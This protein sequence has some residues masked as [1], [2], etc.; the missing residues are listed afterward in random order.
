MKMSCPFLDRL[1]VICRKSK[2]VK[3]RAPFVVLEAIYRVTNVFIVLKDT[4]NVRYLYM[5]YKTIL[6]AKSQD[7]Y[8]FF[9]KKSEFWQR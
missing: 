1:L 7:P 8:I 2:Y 3:S 6:H 9:E 4:H 5:F